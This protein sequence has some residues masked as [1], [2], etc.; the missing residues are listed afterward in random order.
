[1]LLLYFLLEG[2]LV[3]ALLMLLFLDGAP[4]GGTQASGPHRESGAR[5]EPFEI[6]AA[7]RWARRIVCRSDERLEFMG[8]GEAAEVVERHATPNP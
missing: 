8:A 7:A 2:G 6:R 3:A 5:Q 4:G 1:M